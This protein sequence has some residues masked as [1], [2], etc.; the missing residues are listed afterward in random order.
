MHFY[1]GEILALQKVGV[2][3]LVVGNVV[4]VH[5]N[6]TKC[7]MCTNFTDLNKCCLKD[8]PPLQE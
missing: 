8:D 5:K 4:M 1:V 7:R 6:N 2:T 3:Q